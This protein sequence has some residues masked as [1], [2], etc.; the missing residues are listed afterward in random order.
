MSVDAVPASP[1][2]ETIV[3]SWWLRLIIRTILALLALWA[4]AFAE[5]RYEAWLLSIRRFRVDGLSDFWIWLSWIGAAAGGGLLFGLATWFPFT[6]LRFAWSRLLLAGVAV[7]PIAQYWW[8]F[9]YQL[10]RHGEVGGWLYRAGW[11][12]AASTQTAL[13]A[14]AGIAIASAFRA[15]S[16]EAVGAHR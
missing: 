11:F 8:V 16:S 12:F 10:Q 1:S 4:L 15:K 13:A 2:R 14:L 7:V 5:D 9:I 3:A 6:S